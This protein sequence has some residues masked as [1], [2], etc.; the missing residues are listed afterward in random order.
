MKKQL[1]FAALGLSLVSTAVAEPSATEAL[2]SKAKEAAVNKTKEVVDTAK[3]KAKETMTK[4]KEAVET[5]TKEATTK[6]I[7]V[8]AKSPKAKETSDKTAADPK[9]TEAPAT[10]K[11]PEAPKLDDK[12]IK[13]F[14]SYGIGFQSAMQLAGAGI[15]KE[16]IKQAEFRKGFLAALAGEQ[17]KYTPE[18]F[19]AAMTGLNEAVTKREKEL[20]EQNL[21]KETAFL[22]E[23]AKK[24]GV[25]TTESGLQYM[26]I[27]KGGDKKYIAPDPKE[28]PNGVDL[29]T[30]FNLSYTGTLIDGSE[31]DSSK[32]ETVPF[33]LQVV[34][35]FAEALKLM[36]V[37][38][39]WKLFIPSKLGYGDRRN[40]PK[41]QPNSTLIFEVS[42]KEIT[43]RQAPAGFPGI[44]GGAVPRR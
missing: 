17:P 38:S 8:P 11:Q 13:E 19:N 33:T 10:P 3:S 36:P 26:I 14:S 32:G 18:Q 2:E 9:A 24:E 28:T 25:K 16:D 7:E 40:G 20:G 31:F 34:P 22:A 15:K 12:Q 37:G 44:P 21:A 42:L 41:L 23:N 29:Q 27:E 30:Q 43:K 5:K 1:T 6:P 4:A 39:T 35:G